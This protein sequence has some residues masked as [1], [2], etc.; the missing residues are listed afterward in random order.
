MREG[1]LTMNGKERGRKVVLESVRRG[2]STLLEAAQTM[3]VSYRQ[4]KRI[5]ARYV[6]EGDAG[7]VHRGRGR[8]SP[9][10]HPQAFRTAVLAAYEGQL[11][12]LGPTLAAEKLA[13][14]GLQVNHET[15]RRWLIEVGLWRR[16]RKRGPHRTRRERRAR[17]GELLQLDGSDHAWFGAGQR[18]CMLMSLVDDATGRAMT[19]LA[20]GETTEAAMH[21]LRQWVKRYGVPQALYVDGKSVYITDRAPTMEEQLRGETPLTSFGK[22]CEKLGIRIVRAY[23]PQAKGRVERKHGVYQ[24]RLVAEIRLRGLASIGAVNA[25]LPAFDDALNAKFAKPAREREDGHRRLPKRLALRD[26]FCIDTPRSVANDY[27]VRHDNRHYQILR[28]NDPL[29]RPREKVLVRAHFDGSLEL[30][31][32]GRPLVFERIAEP[33]QPPQKPSRAE[34]ALAKPPPNKARPPKT[35]HPWKRSCLP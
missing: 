17:F 22:A 30:L 1:R 13:E 11:L 12:D 31:Y 7:L 26:V 24:Q 27:T 3:G 20:P 2:E 25:L 16:S 28:L 35:G 21:V 10:A 14:R 19:Y 18:R 9:R 5:W 4:A 29:P 34:T 23:S 6:R 32:R 33:P 15:L 8:A